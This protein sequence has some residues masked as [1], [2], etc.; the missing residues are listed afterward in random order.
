MKMEEDS[1]GIKRMKPGLDTVSFYGQQKAPPRKKLEDF[2]L[3]TLTATFAVNDLNIKIP[4]T[5][6]LDRITKILK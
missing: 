4:Y 5:N 1:T 6:I 3:C 2:R